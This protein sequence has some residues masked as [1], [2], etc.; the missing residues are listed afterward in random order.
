MHTQFLDEGAEMGAGTWWQALNSV[1]CLTDK[2]GRRQ[3]REWH[4]HGLVE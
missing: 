3:I 1:T 4:L 2:M